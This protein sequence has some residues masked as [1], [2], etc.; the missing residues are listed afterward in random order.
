MSTKVALERLQFRVTSLSWLQ[1][2]A[3]GKAYLRAREL[4]LLYLKAPGSRVAMPRARFIQPS[5]E[6]T[7]REVGYGLSLGRPLRP[8]RRVVAIPQVSGLPVQQ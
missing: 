1:G 6:R 7:V 2:A 4:A 5:K 8:S 3:N